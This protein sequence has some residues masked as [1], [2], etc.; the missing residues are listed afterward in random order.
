M[1]NATKRPIC[2][3]GFECPVEGFR[4]CAN[5]NTCKDQCVSWEIP[6][7]KNGDCL[8]VRRY[9]HRRTW[10]KQG[11]NSNG[12]MPLCPLPSGQYLHISYDEENEG[13]IRQAWEAAGWKAADLIPQ[14]QNNTDDIDPIPF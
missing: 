13:R 2:P 14:V 6:Y 5:L 7:E 11:T 3:L 9:A 1:E 12:K 8:T 4:Q 10:T